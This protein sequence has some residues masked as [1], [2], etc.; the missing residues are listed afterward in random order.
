VHISSSL[1]RDADRKPLHIVSQI[2]DVTGRKR[3]E[4]KL[5][6]LAERDSLTGVLNRRRFHEELDDALARLRRDG[7]SSALLLVD[8]DR[9]KLVNDTRG[10]KVGDDVLVEVASV[11]RKRLRARDVVGRIGGDEFAALLDGA[12]GAVAVMVAREL[13]GALHLRIPA[14]DTEVAVSASIGVVQLD[15]VTTGEAALI[16]A[17]RALYQAKHAGRDRVAVG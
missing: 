7:G 13:L 3:A 9:F 11:L 15:P 6:D 17:D 16:A 10:H 12:N 14:G 8:L 4:T 2:E 5:R 1:V